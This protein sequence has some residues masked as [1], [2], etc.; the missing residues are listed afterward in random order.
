MQST[1]VYN[2]YISQGCETCDEF[3]V[4]WDP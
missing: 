4:W 1:T 2:T 3:K